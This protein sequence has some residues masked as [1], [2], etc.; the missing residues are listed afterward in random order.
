M[1][2]EDAVVLARM[3]TPPAIA[4][5]YADDSM[6]M[7]ICLCLE[8]QAH[9]PDGR[10]FL[11]CRNAGKVIGVS[12]ETAAAMLRVLCNDG[13]LERISQGTRGHAAEYQYVH[14]ENKNS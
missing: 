3:A 13:V 11:D 8:L 12:H 9:A 10:F 2:L 6:A 14:P 5:R 7:L 4:S 1:T